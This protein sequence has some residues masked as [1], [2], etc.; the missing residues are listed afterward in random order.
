[1]F[2]LAT[3]FD[4]IFD[5]TQHSVDEIDDDAAAFADEPID[6]A[7]VSNDDAAVLKMFDID[8]DALN[9]AIDKIN[10]DSF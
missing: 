7:P 2:Y 9:A 10:S 4:I 3:N 1:M 5:P 8:L 6:D